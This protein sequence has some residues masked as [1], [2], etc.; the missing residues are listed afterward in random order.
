MM[1]SLNCNGKSHENN[2]CIVI[3]AG[4]SEYILY[5]KKLSWG[6]Y[7]QTGVIEQ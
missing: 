1:P 3:S 6:V 2:A 7:E 5:N 4:A